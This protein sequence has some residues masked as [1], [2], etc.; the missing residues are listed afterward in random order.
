M[1]IVSV[2]QKLYA[3]ISNKVGGSHK[4]A[5]SFPLRA[6]QDLKITPPW[7]NGSIPTTIAFLRM[8]L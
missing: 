8:Q 2:Q 3:K 4:I 5:Y 6:F 7:I 1:D